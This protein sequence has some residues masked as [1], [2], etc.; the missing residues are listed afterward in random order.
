MK[1]KVYVLH[2]LVDRA[3]RTIGHFHA[4]MIFIQEVPHV[5]F[6]WEVSPNGDE[7]PVHLAELDPRFLHKVQDQLID[8]MYEYPVKD[9]RPLQ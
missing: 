3:G 6:E 7:R 5:A 4:D 2:C 8:Y 9:P 1:N